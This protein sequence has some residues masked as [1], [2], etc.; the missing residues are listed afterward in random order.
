MKKAVKSLEKAA[1]DRVFADLRFEPVFK[2]KLMIN[3]AK[4]WINHVQNDFT[5]FLSDCSVRRTYLNGIDVEGL[6][7][8]Y[9]NLRPP[10][11]SQKPD[12]LCSSI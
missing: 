7:D 5:T 9:F 8:D 1:K 2:D 6:V 3:E 12:E 4:E 11:E 10:F